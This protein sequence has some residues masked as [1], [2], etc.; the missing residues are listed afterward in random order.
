MRANKGERLLLIDTWE[1]QFNSAETIFN[2]S[3][4]VV[5]NDYIRLIIIAIYNF[6]LQFQLFEFANLIY[7]S[8][9][10]CFHFDAI[11]QIL[12]SSLITKA[13]KKQLRIK[14]GRLKLCRSPRVDAIDYK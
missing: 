9:C 11:C 2:P 14:N 1:A 4:S 13:C 6:L 5:S 3:F 12:K 7:V 8:L 10:I